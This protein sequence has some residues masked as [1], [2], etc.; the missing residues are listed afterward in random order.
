MVVGLPGKATVAHFPFVNALYV[1]LRLGAHYKHPWLAFSR[2]WFC[3]APS[4]ITYWQVAWKNKAK[5]MGGGAA[6]KTG[7]GETAKSPEKTGMCSWEMKSPG[8]P[9]LYLCITTTN[10]LDGRKITANFA[11]PCFIRKPLL[12]LQSYN[13]WGK[14][15]KFWILANTQI[16]SGLWGQLLPF[17]LCLQIPLQIWCHVLA[18][19]F[20]ISVFVFGHGTL[21]NEVWR[22]Y[23]Q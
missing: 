14:Y 8:P 16:H 3:L 11:L 23:F 21:Y 20:L 13:K 7:A 9:Q 18:W 5:I 19:A 6:L 2:W 10:I 15:L 1:W 4:C 22:N 12:L 17:S